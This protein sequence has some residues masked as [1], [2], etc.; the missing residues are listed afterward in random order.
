MIYIIHDIFHVTTAILFLIFLLFSLF[1]WSMQFKLLLFTWLMIFFTIHMNN[2]YPWFFFSLSFF[3]IHIISTNFLAI[4]TR[5]VDFFFFFCCNFFSLFFFIVRINILF[6][7]FYL[8]FSYSIHMKNAISFFFS[9]FHCTINMNIVF[10]IFFC[11]WAWFFCNLTLS[12]YISKV[13]YVE[14][15][16]CSHICEMTKNILIFN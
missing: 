6:F 2:L 12:S 11:H 15:F 1:T 16:S 13:L 10:F 5:I 8:F 4:F 3:T 7:V 14:F 9:I